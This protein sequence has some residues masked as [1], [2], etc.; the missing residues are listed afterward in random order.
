MKSSITSILKVIP[1]VK[2]FALAIMVMAVA[3]AIGTLVNGPVWKQYFP[4]GSFIMLLIATWFLFRREGTS[5]K[6]LGLD[7]TL[8]NGS[9]VFLGLLLGSGAFLVANLVRSI[10]T[11]ESIS[12][13]HT[14]DYQT[15]F[16]SLY[17]ILPTVAVEELLFRGYLF[18]KTIAVTNVV[19]ANIVFAI[20]FMLIHVVDEHVLRSPGMMVMLFISIPVGH[21]LFATALLKSRTL[22]FP[23]GLH[24]GNNW[25]S[26]H[27]ISDQGDGQS[28]LVVMERVQFDSWPSFI[29][30]LLLYNGVFL[31]VILLIWKW[32]NWNWQFSGGKSL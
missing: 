18:K 19:I 14:I 4:Y 25:A 31:L 26:R 5:L 28:I 1:K 10:Y 15:V 7:L 23:I 21:L 16:T 27:L 11:G 6:S 29:G 24:L 12:L 13:S 8:R 3:L 2:T 30:L 17:F 32:K 22:Y 20:I 9:F